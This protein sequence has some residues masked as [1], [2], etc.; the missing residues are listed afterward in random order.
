M[1]MDKTFTTCGT[2]IKID[3][4]DGIVT[5]NLACP[6]NVEPV[7]Y[8]R[9]YTSLVNPQVANVEILPSYP[10]PSIQ[11]ET[12]RVRALYLGSG[13]ICANEPYCH[14]WLI[15]YPGDRI[16]LGTMGNYEVYGRNLIPMMDMYACPM[17]DYISSML[18]RTFINRF[19]FKRI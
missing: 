1:D 15:P 7:V 14:Y 6:Q 4:F 9:L 18:L 8:G 10:L 19:E 17:F 16:H 13:R 2:E 5:E 3:T 12:H 11:N